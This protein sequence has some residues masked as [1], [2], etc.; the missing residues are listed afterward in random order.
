MLRLRANTGFVI[1][2]NY[3]VA[4][5]AIIISQIGGKTQLVNMTPTE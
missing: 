2:S 1:A 3:K 4:A 5:I